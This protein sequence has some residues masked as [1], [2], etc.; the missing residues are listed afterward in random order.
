MQANHTQ[1]KQS[2]K[3]FFLRQMIITQL[4]VFPHLHLCLLLHFHC[5]LVPTHLLLIACHFFLK[6]NSFCLFLKASFLVSR[7]WIWRDKSSLQSHLLSCCKC[8]RFP[9]KGFGMIRQQSCVAF[10][11]QRDECLSSSCYFS[12]Q[13]I[14]SKIFQG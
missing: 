6:V 7:G 11:S 1:I 9:L 4:F 2:F 5:V 10:G 3:F 8:P 13:Q 12:L 14:A